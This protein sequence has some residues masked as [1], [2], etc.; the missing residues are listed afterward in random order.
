MRLNRVCLTGV[1]A[2]LAQ[3]V[4]AQVTEASLRAEASRF[5]ALILSDYDFSKAKVTFPRLGRPSLTLGSITISFDNGGKVVTYKSDSKVSKPGT[6][7]KTESDARRLGDEL[8]RK[9]GLSLE[10]FPKVEVDLSG[11]AM[12]AV[13]HER[14][15]GALVTYTDHPYGYPVVGG[16][17][18]ELDLDFNSGHVVSLLLRNRNTYEKPDIRLDLAEAAQSAQTYILEDQFVAKSAWYARTKDFAEDLSNLKSRARL[19]FSGPRLVGTLSQRSDEPLRKV[20]CYEFM[21]PDGFAMI[22]A[23][24]GALVNLGLYKGAEPI[25]STSSPIAWILGA[26]IAIGGGLVVRSRLRSKKPSPGR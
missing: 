13:F 22:S 25:S 6:R 15:R 10:D 8:V 12:K 18:L 17:S 3:A 16:N 24:S 4:V 20:L 5:C 26:V 7:I 14:A 9:L 1:L 11:R 23:R 2:L 21:L 19:V